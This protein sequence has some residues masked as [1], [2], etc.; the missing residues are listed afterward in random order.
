MATQ[1]R[2]DCSEKK[3]K[4]KNKTK[5]KKKKKKQQTKYLSH[6]TLQGTGIMILNDIE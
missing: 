3:T 6:V 5:K 1:F 4:Q 2:V